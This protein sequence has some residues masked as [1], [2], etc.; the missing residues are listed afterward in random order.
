MIMAWFYIKRKL[1]WLYSSSKMYIFFLIKERMVFCSPYMVI[2][3]SDS[4]ANF[5]KKYIIT[6]VIFW[7]AMGYS[8]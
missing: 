2:S 7:K 6:Y 8:G 4:L 3:L 5:R 1:W